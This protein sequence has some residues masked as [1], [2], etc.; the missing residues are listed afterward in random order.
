MRIKFLEGNGDS[1]VDIFRKL[2]K[3]KFPQLLVEKNPELYLVA[4]GDGA[5]LHA[6]QEN[7]DDNIPYIGKAMGTFNF[8]MNHFENDEM[9]IQNLLDNKLSFDIFESN[10]IL[11]TL[12]GNKIGEA[13]NDV[14]L[15]R[16]ITDYY[17]FSISTES[18]DFNDFDVKGSGIC[19]STPIGSTA[20]NY[21]NNGRILPLNADF[22]SITGIVTNRFL[23]DIV[24]F[25]KIKIRSNG[26]DIFL[27]NVKGGILAEGDELLL[28]KGSKIKIAFLDKQDFLKRRIE[29]GHRF[30]K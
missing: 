7:I 21:N 27:T 14:I 23:N 13:V 12:N 28:E 9:V 11:A 20:F 16:K 4:G 22:L 6:I 17:S 18:G 5:M 1:R 25:G 3:E 2:V 19:I 29:I 8:L 30:R 24:P 15:G 10:A 26:S